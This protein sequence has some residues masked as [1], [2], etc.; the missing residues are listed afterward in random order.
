M[1]RLEATPALEAKPAQDG[2][3]VVG[4]F[5]TF[6]RYSTPEFGSTKRTELGFHAV[7]IKDKTDL[8]FERVVVG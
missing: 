3:E 6:E 8:W 2:F 4:T 1:L 5:G 7:L